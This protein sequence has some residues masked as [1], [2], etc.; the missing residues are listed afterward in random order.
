MDGHVGGDEDVLDGERHTGDG[1]ELLPGGAA[2]VDVGGRLERRGVDV[3]EGVHVAVDGGDAVE[4][5]LRRLD[6]GD[7]AR[8]ELVGEVGGAQPREVAHCSSPGSR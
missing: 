6:A 7:L 1:A 3:Q 4:V 8:C 5:G 2:A